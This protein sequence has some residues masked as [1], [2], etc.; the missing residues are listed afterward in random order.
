MSWIPTI[1]FRIA[2]WEDTSAFSD[3][4][5][6]IDLYDSTDDAILE[7]DDLQLMEEAEYL[8]VGSLSVYT[9]AEA[10][11]IRDCE[12]EDMYCNTIDQPDLRDGKD[13]TVALWQSVLPHNAPREAKPVSHEPQRGLTA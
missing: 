6:R 4:Y 1:T 2:G 8:A 12:D 13:T 10:E 11:Y 5:G 3:K 7:A 9:V